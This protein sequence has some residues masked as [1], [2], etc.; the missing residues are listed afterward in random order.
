MTGQ[1]DIQ[2]T[3]C[4]G[5]LTISTVLLS[6]SAW[7]LPDLSSL[8]ATPDVRGD[9]RLI[10]GVTGVKAY[11]RRLT[12]SRYSLPMIVAGK[13]TRTGALNSNW[14]A[15]LEANLAYLMAN[16]LL[17]TGTGDGT[18]TCVWTLPSGA[19]VTA[20][21]HVYGF[22]SPQLFPGSLLRGTLELSAP[23]GDLHL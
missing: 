15:G 8:W 7:C 18:R 12:A 2:C 21:V 16:V 6:G 9:D 23:H 14:Q 1:G 5:T 22:V 17:P 3:S 13:Y 20:A 4:Y 19:T 11:P 10:P